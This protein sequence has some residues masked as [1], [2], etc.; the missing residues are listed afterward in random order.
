MTRHFLQ[1]LYSVQYFTVLPG[2]IAF[3]LHPSYAC[4][5]PSTSFCLYSWVNGYT[6]YR[7]SGDCHSHRILSVSRLQ[8]GPTPRSSSRLGTRLIML[9]CVMSHSQVRMFSCN[10]FIFLILSKGSFTLAPHG[11][12]SR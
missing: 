1:N 11:I 5:R 3:C 12:H 10:Y 2:I 6:T 4:I 7:A 9:F 8:Q